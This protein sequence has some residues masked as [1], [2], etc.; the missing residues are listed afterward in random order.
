LLNPIFRLVNTRSIRFALLDF[1]QQLAAVPHDV[2]Q[3]VQCRVR[4]VGDGAAFADI[5]R[6]IGRDDR[7]DTFAQGMAGVEGFAKAD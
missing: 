3:I 7:F 4:A 5:G 2:A 1:Q 6:R